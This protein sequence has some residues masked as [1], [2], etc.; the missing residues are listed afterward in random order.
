M[1]VHRFTPEHRAACHDVVSIDAEPSQARH[2]YRQRRRMGGD[3]PFIA[4]LCTIGLYAPEAR[5]EAVKP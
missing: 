2:E 3:R 5:P 4:R 1:I